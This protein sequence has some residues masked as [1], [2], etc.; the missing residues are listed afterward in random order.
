MRRP[1]N[2][3]SDLGGS[4]AL[5]MALTYVAVGITYLF[6]P[7]DLKVVGMGDP[8]VY[9]PA[10]LKDPTPALMLDWETAVMGLLGV[11][12]VLAVSARVLHEL[13]NGWI[14]YTGFL[15]LFGF[16]LEALDS[17]RG[18]VFHLSRAEAWVHGDAST[19]AAIGATRLT[20]DYYGW[21]AFGA[22]GLWILAVSVPRISSEPA[23][24][25]LGYLGVA[26][27]IGNELL[28]LGWTFGVVSLIDLG[29]FL[30]ALTGIPWFTWMGLELRRAATPHAMPAAA[31]T[32]NARPSM[33]SREPC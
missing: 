23:A 31:A 33:P 19:R 9:Y 4:C 29:V 1:R 16:A 17:L 30:G 6:L 3:L 7:R 27:A 25:G 5:L 21:F 10:L 24:S 14:V 12:I 28:V 26:L 32:D 22:V 8:A 2:E 20:L 15:A 11:A 13:S 18:T